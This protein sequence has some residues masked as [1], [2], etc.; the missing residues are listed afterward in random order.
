MRLAAI[1]VGTNSIHM[2]IA[3]VDPDGHFRVIDRAKEMV[4]FGKGGL[5]RG[6][7]SSAAMEQGVRTLRAF[8]TLADRLGVARYQAVATS[9]VREAS[10]GGDFIQRVRDEVG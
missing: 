3:Q 4:G 2:L 1:D 7:L 9:A 10:N 6:R 5:T 8:R